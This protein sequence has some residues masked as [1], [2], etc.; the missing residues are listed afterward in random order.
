[1]ENPSANKENFKYDL[2]VSYS[3]DPDYK[4]VHKLESFLESFHQL[5]TPKELSPSHA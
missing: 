2:F 5:K 1:M 4:L 3:T